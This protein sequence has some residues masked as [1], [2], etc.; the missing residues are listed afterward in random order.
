MAGRRNNELTP[1]E[2]RN[3]MVAQGNELI[4][5][6]R[7]QYSEQEQNVIYFMISRVKP[8]DK[9][10][11]TQTFTIKELCK[12]LGLSPDQGKNIAD[13]KAAIKNLADKSAW[14]EV[15][16]GK[17]VLVR[18]VD[19]YTIDHNKNTI[20]A[21]ISQSMEPFLIGL[22]ERGFY[23]QSE[24]VYFLALQSKYSKRMYE[25]LRS[26]INFRPEYQ[27]RQI[28]QY[29]SIDELR[30]LLGVG[31]KLPRFN[32]FKR[33]AIKLSIQQINQLTDIEILYADE[34]KSGRKVTGMTFCFR[35]RDNMGRFAAAKTANGVLVR[36]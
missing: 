34:E 12:V 30:G 2:A 23:T 4:R 21:R 8:D 33:N 24:L 27:N 7:N 36:H 14:V 29:Y 3:M 19:T 31:D 15:Q 16:D 6:A 18:W 10:L 25:I 22:R 5:H 20:E 9:E 35:L 32:D 28:I 11:M 26:Y 17:E 1:E 13:M